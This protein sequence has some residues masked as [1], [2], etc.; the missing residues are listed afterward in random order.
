M[1]I[2]DDQVNIHFIDCPACTDDGECI[3]DSSKA[4][5]E[6]EKLRNLLKELYEPAK[7]AVNQ[8]ICMGG[9]TICQPCENREQLAIALENV[10]IFMEKKDE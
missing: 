6:L 2:L 5:K 7:I 9:D 3:C 4:M 10:E 1:T 8:T